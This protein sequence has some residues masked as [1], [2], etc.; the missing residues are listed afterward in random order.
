MNPNIKY[1]KDSEICR[2]IANKLNDFLL[3]N[4]ELINRNCGKEQN[5]LLVIFD[6][7]EDPIT[8]LLHQFTYQVIILYK[9]NDS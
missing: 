4:P 9:G 2:L 6:R 1:S 7:R 8:P 3:N 5:T